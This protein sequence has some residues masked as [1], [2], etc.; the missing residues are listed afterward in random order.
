MVHLLGWLGGWFHHLDKVL[1]DNGSVSRNR[2]VLTNGKVAEARFEL[3]SPQ[4]RAAL[5]AAGSK[6]CPGFVIATLTS[7]FRVFSCRMLVVSIPD[8]SLILARCS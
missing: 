3:F 2:V 7:A 8:I 1:Y 6:R 4:L 5:R